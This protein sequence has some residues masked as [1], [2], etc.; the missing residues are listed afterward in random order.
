MKNKNFVTELMQYGV[1]FAMSFLIIVVLALAMAVFVA[2]V[3]VVAFF[4]RALH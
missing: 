2:M 3:A 1:G 4:D